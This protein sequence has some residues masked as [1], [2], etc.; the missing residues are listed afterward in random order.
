MRAE[1]L[2][3]FDSS[4]AYGEKED[5]FKIL[6]KHVGKPEWLSPMAA[7]PPSAELHDRRGMVEGKPLRFLEVP[8]QEYGDKENDDLRGQPPG[9][10][11]TVKH[12]IRTYT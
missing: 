12:G 1:S 6:C 8:V 9:H 11:E 3:R 5:E 7:G 4:Y 2:L 10:Q